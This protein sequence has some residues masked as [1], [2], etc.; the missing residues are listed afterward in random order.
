MFL[1]EENLPTLTWQGFER[2][3]SRYLICNAFEGIRIVGKTGDRGADIIGHKYGKRWLFQAKNW[4]NKAGLA[5]LKETI[6]ACKVY[7][8]SQ[9]VIVS[10]N[11]F[12]DG[13]REQQISYLN[14]KVNLQ[15]WSGLDLC[16]LVKKLPEVTINKNPPRPYQEEAIQQ[17]VN[18][19][20]AGVRNN[21]LIVMATGLG[22]TFVMAEA[23]RRIKVNKKINVLVLAHTNELVYQLEK[24]FWPFLKPT[25]KTIIWNG[26]ERPDLS[27]LNGASVVFGCI[28]SVSD[29]K[30]GFVREIC[31][32]I[33]IVD[34]CHHVGG[35][36]YMSVLKELRAGQE[37]GPFL[38]GLSATPWRPDE[39]EIQSIFGPPLISI[40]MIAGLKKGFL[41]N[42]DYRIYTDNIDWNSLTKL[43]GSKFSPRNINKT[44]FITE[45][46]DG[47]VTELVKV[48]RDQ[49][50]PRGIVFCGTINHALQM[51]DRINAIGI[52]NAQAIYSGSVEGK[53]M[54]QFERNR[55]LCDF[56][57]GKINIVCAVDIFNE[58]V[59]VPDVNI[60]VF[61]RVTHSRRIFVQQ[62][63]RGLRLA[64]DKE[65]VIVLDF[66]SDI[67]RFAAGLSL[68]RDLN[69]TEASPG[70]NIQNISINHKVSFK[71]A[72]QDD[73]ES[74]LF[75]K[76]WLEEVAEIEDAGEDSSVLKF[77]P[78]FKHSK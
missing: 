55:I 49:Q 51:R 64:P 4:K 41:A 11:G 20:F 28:N 42:V 26:L 45:W 30:D 16:N 24:A 47:V 38:I 35:E 46:D 66:V 19:F 27:S 48:W 9:P 12:E 67:R 5:V 78:K 56:Q 76:K 1:D 32:D 52:C 21:A 10:A 71:R 77:P 44:L 15:L 60:I 25:E 17:L 31:P 22:K 14:N 37:G 65:K 69:N 54:T 73:I 50:K 36:M 13:V 34:E 40:D 39:V 75:L 43:N 29:E 7:S 3:L 57:D 74:E 23:L 18:T 8:A 58:G 63:G 59:D 72:G 33:V 68:Q 62:L 53:I 70:K 2:N 61:Q 6:E